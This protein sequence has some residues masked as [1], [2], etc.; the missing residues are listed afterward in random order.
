MKEIRLK[1]DYIKLG[2]ALKFSGLAESGIEAKLIILDGKV[3]VNGGTELQRGK[4][5]YPGDIV[6]CQNETIKIVKN[7]H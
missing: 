3:K 4:K 2:Q 5:L 7:D 6:S 1:K